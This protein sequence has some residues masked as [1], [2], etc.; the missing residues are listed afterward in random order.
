MK[1]KNSYTKVDLSV[2]STSITESNN[3]EIL[4][5]DL[6]HCTVASCYKPPEVWFCFSLPDNYNNQKTQ[7]LNGDFNS[8][9]SVWVYET[10][11]E[12]ESFIHDIK[13]SPSFNSGRWSKG[14]NPDIFFVSDSMCRF[15][16]RAFKFCYCVRSN[17]LIQIKKITTTINIGNDIH[18][19][20]TI[21]NIFER[22]DLIMTNYACVRQKRSQRA[23]MHQL[24]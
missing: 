23:I 16:L 14:H 20:W 6:N 7:F 21:Y 9:S 18:I 22:Y 19:N 12:K 24:F 10:D 15:R 8:H 1:T 3:I 5:V 4:T 2:L 11:D 17:R 13:L